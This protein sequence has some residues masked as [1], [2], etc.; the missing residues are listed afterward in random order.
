MKSV[1]GHGFDRYKLAQAVQSNA[2]QLAP[3]PPEELEQFRQDA[4][5]ERRDFLINQASPQELRQAARS[6]AE[7][8]RIQFQRAEAER[9]IAFRE[10]KDA[11]VGY[12]PL[13]EVNGEGQKIDAAYLNKISNTNLQ[14]FKNL[15][16][17]HGASNLT[18]R[19]RGIR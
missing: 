15:M 7:Q 16:R 8:R 18:A 5:E 1:L 17:R 19:L 4:A 3:A 11:A 12:P 9:Q 14:L 6:E 13:P 2:L 10:Q